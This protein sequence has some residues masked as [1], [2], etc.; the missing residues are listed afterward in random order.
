MKRSLLVGVLLSRSFVSV[1]ILV[2]LACLAVEASPASASSQLYGLTANASIELEGR[3]PAPMAGT[4]R[5]A[6]SGLCIAPPG[7]PMSCSPIAY[8]VQELDLGAEGIE[9]RK[10]ALPEI[11]PPRVIGFNYDI[12]L[13]E[14]NG[15]RL[16][17]LVLERDIL[18]EGEN[19]PGEGYV[20][21]RELRLAPAY[22]IS[23]PGYGE[24]IF[25][26]PDRYPS[27]LQ[28]N[29]V[30][31]N[32]EATVIH[33]TNGAE[34]G[35]IH[36]PHIEPGSEFFERLGLVTIHA[37]A[38][39][40]PPPPLPA[41]GEFIG[42]GP[43]RGVGY[44]T[45]VSDDGRSVSGYARRSSSISTH[46][47]R[48]TQG[49]GYRTPLGNIRGLGT[50]R[51]YAISP[52]GATVAGY[53]DSAHYSKPRHEAARWNDA[54]E[55]E[56]LIGPPEYEQSV[57]EDVTS[58]GEVVGWVQVL[59]PYRIQAQ[60]WDVDGKRIPLPDLPSGG[61]PPFSRAHA[62]SEDGAVIVG[63]SRSD[64]HLQNVAARWTDAGVESLGAL[65]EGASSW[66]WDVSADGSTAVGWS[67]NRSSQ[68]EAFRWTEAK[69]MVALGDLPGGEYRSEAY[70]VSAD[71]WFVVGSST[72]E[73]GEEA[74]VWDP[75]HGMRRLQDVLEHALGVDL[76]DWQLVR[77]TGITPDGRVI[78][79][80]GINSEGYTEAW[81]GVLPEPALQV[82]IDIEPRR[83]PN[84]IGLHGWRW[85]RVAMLGSEF[86]DVDKLDV[87]SIAFGPD[88]AEPAHDLTHRRLYRFHR[89]DVNHDGYSDLLLHFR[90]RDTG[91]GVSD[92]EA[93]LSGELDGEA[94]L[95][96]D[97][98]EVY[99]IGHD[100]GCWWKRKHRGRSGHRSS[101]ASRELVPAPWGDRHHRAVPA[102]G[103]V[104]SPGGHGVVSP[105]RVGDPSCQVSADSKR[106]GY[107]EERLREFAPMIHAKG[108]GDLVP[109]LAAGIPFP[110][111]DAARC[112]GSPSGS[113]PDHRRRPI[114]P[115][116]A[117]FKPIGPGFTRKLRLLPLRAH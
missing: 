74:F 53:F 95:A 110:D 106:T 68:R 55:L 85:L 40:D 70:A 51:G 60:R 61:A 22:D 57:G 97:S 94:F 90:L 2:A 93:C 47:F 77:A 111:P 3:D 14:A 64:I 34:D 25:D 82:E 31:Q 19:S 4:F 29:Y 42:L 23:G 86:V 92:T 101:C 103:R 104:V 72:T 58:A 26:Q 33:D 63:V 15:L 41:E 59:T 87:S 30:L 13:D 75:R 67:N 32:Y 37:V 109:R 65:A 8:T 28:L 44:A 102:A 112:L 54:L 27:S 20:N 107:L 69:G 99:E 79:G 98:V 76:S 17:P 88:Q 5:L 117:F 89:K 16:G 35:V 114:Y 62:L 21:F 66:A 11:P 1:Q 84:R 45:G 113:M 116:T 83:S 80:H 49:T 36:L 81:R 48:W 18:S 91:I 10:Q 43:G 12:R 108:E 7:G 38:I 24:L 9:L 105:E 46:G 73:Q 71:G 56:R 50:S 100:H 52:D 115:K 96:C 78:V 39:P 6:F